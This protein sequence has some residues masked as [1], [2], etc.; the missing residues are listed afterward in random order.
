MLWCVGGPG[1]G[2][3][4]N[5][6]RNIN[7]NMAKRKTRKQVPWAGWGKIA[8]RGHARTV[9]K[10][11]CGKKCFLGPK[12]S[13][14]VCAKGTCKVNKKGAYAAYVRAKQWGNRRSSYKSRGKMIK[15]K[16]KSKKVYMKGSRPRHERRTYK[17]VARKAKRILRRKF[18]IKVGK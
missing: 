5:K 10:R 3:S 4:K 11:R 6:N 17:K 7:Y 16:G 9:M 1:I 14:P 2:G 12:K 15:Y 13:F 18:G 8:P